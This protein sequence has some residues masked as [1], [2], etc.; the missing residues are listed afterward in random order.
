MKLCAVQVPYPYTIDTADQAVEFVIDTLHACDSS[1]DLIL[2]PE[3][4]NAPTVFPAGECIPYAEKHTKRLIAAA[5]ETARRCQAIVAVNHACEMAPG[6]FRNTTRVFDCNGEI[7]GDFYKQHLPYKETHVKMMDDSY[8]RRFLPPEIIEV[9]GIRLASLI[10]YDTYFYEYIAHI[11]YRKP[12]IVL[13]SSHQRAEYRHILMMQNQHL[14][15]ACNSYVLRASVSMGENAETGGCSLVAS[16]DGRIVDDFGNKTGLFCCEIA[17]PHY[18][19]TRSNCFGGKMIPSDQ[20]MEQGRTP[21]SYRPCGSMVIEGEEKLPYPRVCAHRGFNTVAPE[22]SLPAFGAA[23]ALGTE[24]IELDIRFSRD[25]IPVICHDDFLERVSDGRGMLEDLPFAE[26]RKLDF[27]SRF[28]N[29]FAGLKIASLEEVLTRFA[30]QVI[31]NMHIK[32]KMG[33]P[34]PSQRLL[35]LVKLLERYDHLQHVYIVGGVEVMKCACEVAPQIPRC[36]GA[37][38]DHWKIV[39]RAIEYQCQK[40]QLFAPD[41]NRDMI[42]RAH[43]HGIRCNLFFCDNPE[44]VAENLQMGVDTIL[45]NDYL[46]IANAVKQYQARP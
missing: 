8:T 34:F 17:D 16:P 30:R 36:M 44:K 4:S 3:Y 37:S 21:W 45:T 6:V 25:G 22:N 41:Y 31:I 39:D 1:C 15:F 40:I 20:F 43:A 35:Q 27:G 32:S 9:N 2:T 26:L 23:I 42:D 33:E 46:T 10:C 19:Y 18:K 29:R 24:E 5:R 13:V 38:P 28:G 12:D 11:A 7:A 14:A